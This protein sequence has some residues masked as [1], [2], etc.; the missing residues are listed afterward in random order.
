MRSDPSDLGYPHFALEVKDVEAEHKRLS[1]AG[2]S[3]VGPPVD[4]GSQKAVY[5]RDP[6][7]NI[8]EL[9]EELDA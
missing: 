4:V 3:F 5:G 9:L 1:E 7:G 6:F 8:I 2:M